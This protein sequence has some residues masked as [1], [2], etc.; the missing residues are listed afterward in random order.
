MLSP[1]TLYNISVT[2]SNSYGD[3]LPSYYLLVLTRPDSGD[4]YE[5][6]DDDDLDTPDLPDTRDDDGGMFEI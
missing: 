2:A 6:K 4:A 3:S 5:A 1:F